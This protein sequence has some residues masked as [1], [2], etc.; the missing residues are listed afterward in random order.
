MKRWRSV[1]EAARETRATLDKALAEARERHATAREATKQP[2]LD[3]LA[4]Q[5][6][7][8][9]A[10]KRRRDAAEVLARCVEQ[11]EMNAAEAA[12]HNGRIEAAATR[13]A[14]KQRDQAMRREADLIRLIELAIRDKGGK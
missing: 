12:V 4:A 3:A 14:A 2:N 11:R 7:L 8:D 5:D 13:S 10:L 6:A 9:K 1:K